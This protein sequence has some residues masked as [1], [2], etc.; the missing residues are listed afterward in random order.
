MISA[1]Q[2]KQAAWNSDFD[3]VKR[4]VNGSG[5]INPCGNNGVGALVTFNIKILEYLYNHGA[6]PSIIWDDGSPAIGFHAWEVSLESLKWFLDKGVDPNLANTTTAQRA[7][8][9]LFVPSQEI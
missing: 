3:F 2:F 1:D 7:A 4:Y 5:D 6:D 8:C 9:I